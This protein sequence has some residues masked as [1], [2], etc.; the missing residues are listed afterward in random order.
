MLT[1][2]LF[3]VVTVTIRT[4]LDLTVDRMATPSTLE[5]SLTNTAVSC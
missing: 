2:P 1:L 4:T 3:V 5:S